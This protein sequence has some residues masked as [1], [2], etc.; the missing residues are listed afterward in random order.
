MEQDN[1]AAVAGFAAGYV[2]TAAV[3][4]DGAAA[5]IEAELL[6]G[7]AV[8]AVA[9]QA[10]VVVA[11][12]VEALA[13]VGADQAAGIVLV[14]LA[15]VIVAAVVFGV[16]DAVVLPV[17]VDVDQIGQLHIAGGRHQRQQQGGGH[18]FFMWIPFVKTAAKVFQAA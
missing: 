16:V 1:A 2:Q 5:R 6:V 17:R 12:D 18:G 8:A 9:D 11:V 4:A 14:A 13:V 3:L 15:F 7:L 10:V